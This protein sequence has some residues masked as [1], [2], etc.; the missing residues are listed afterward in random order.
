MN[1]KFSKSKF[2]KAPK[3]EKNADRRIWVL[4][5][6][7]ILFSIL[8]AGKLLKI[9]IFDHQ[10]YYALASDQ[11]EI[12]KQLFPV[13]GDILIKDEKVGIFNEKNLYPLATNKEL[14]LVFAKPI[15]IQDPEKVL[16][17]LKEIFHIDDE[18]EEKA[19][20]EKLQKQNDPY[21][22]IKHR[23]DDNTVKKIEE[24]EL[25]GIY[26]APETT[27]YYPEKNI[28]SHIL[29]YV[30]YSDGKGNYGL[31]GYYNDIL[32]GKTGFLQS[33][34][35]SMGRW[36]SVAS[37]KFEK[38]EDGA[39]II[40]TIN[41]S[42]QFYACEELNKAVSEYKAI[43]GSVI[44]MEPQTGKIIAMCSAPDY[45]PNNYNKVS[46]I[47]VFNNEAVAISYEPG[48]IFKPITMA[49]AID[50][51][52]VDPYTTYNDTGQVV[53]ADHTIK[54]SDEKAHGVK[55]MTNVLEESLNTGAIFAARQ[56]GVSVFKNYVQSFGFGQ[57][58]NIEIG[59]E[60]AG[61]IRSLDEPGEIYMATA[62]FGQGITATPIQMAAAYAAIVN[63]GNLVRPY[64][65]DEIHYSNGNVDNIEPKIV[66]RV[67]SERS[68]ELLKGMLVS[69]VKNGH[70]EPAGVPGYLVGGK[71]GTA[72]VSD[73]VK[74]G[75]SDAT[76]HSFVGFAPMDDPKF[77]IIVKL[78]NPHRKYSVMTAA[79]TFGKI[80][81]FIL[82]YYG[83]APTE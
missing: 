60:S 47:D 16:Q 6:I 65:I 14:S 2:E 78:D 22:P 39:N 28:G 83:I 12:F 3:H 10:Y 63:G 51:G 67:I 33:E 35:D 21:E 55:D 34:L 69:V 71:T 5:V 59:L 76:I 9:Q 82:E 13:R 1:K 81:K 18:E 4:K 80:S 53:I 43:G 42:I 77:V 25:E 66:Q 56:I 49:A 20:L 79:P 62:S 44:V 24:L 30:N 7:F 58:T 72:Q 73:K 15:E 26:F 64:A 38:A 50:A 32:S 37:K 8:L 57:K 61:D 29:G 70:A 52:R 23:V 68:S 40:L 17:G 46:D 54:N 36:I 27:R 41:K 31:E 45:D 11:Y 19:I 75:Y 48:S 74:G